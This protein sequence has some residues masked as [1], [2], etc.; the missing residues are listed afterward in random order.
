M[1]C[2]CNI[3]NTRSVTSDIQTERN[4]SVYA[5]HTF[6]R[7]IVE[8]VLN[9]T[10]MMKTMGLKKGGPEPIIILGFWTAGKFENSR[11]IRTLADSVEALGVTPICHLVL[12]EVETQILNGS[13]QVRLA[14]EFNLS[15]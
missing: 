5:Y 14:G 10:L 4:E 15:F 11:K 12:T 7:M 9:G 3:L 13:A 1:E 2:F 6:T 8:P